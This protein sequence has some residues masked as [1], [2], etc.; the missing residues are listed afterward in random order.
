ME[1]ARKV[2]RR[3]SAHNR[4]KRILKYRNFPRKAELSRALQKRAHQFREP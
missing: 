4:G 3:I 2:R 1:N